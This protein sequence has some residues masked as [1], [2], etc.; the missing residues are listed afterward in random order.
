M[1]AQRSLLPEDN[2]PAAS[3][4]GAIATATAHGNAVTGT[5]TTVVSKGALGGGKGQGST[6]LSVAEVMR[7]WQGRKAQR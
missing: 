5:W 3:S 2:A 6:I 7:H 4:S 1:Q